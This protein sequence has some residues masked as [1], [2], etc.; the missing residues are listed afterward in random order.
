MFESC[1]ITSCKSNN[2]YKKNMISLQWNLFL[3]N[4]AILPVNVDKPQEDSFKIIGP[5]F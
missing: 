5:N 4:F 3:P 2:I 1:Y